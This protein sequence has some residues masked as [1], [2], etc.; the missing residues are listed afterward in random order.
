M[1]ILHFVM[2]RKKLNIL[3]KPSKALIWNSICLTLGIPRDLILPS[4]QAFVMH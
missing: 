3:N 1:V 2:L 4:A